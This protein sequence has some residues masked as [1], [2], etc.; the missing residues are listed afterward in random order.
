MKN[1]VTSVV[2]CA[3]LAGCGLTPNGL[4]TPTKTIEADVPVGDA[5]AGVQTRPLARP[6]ASDVVTTPEAA[7]P[8]PTSGDLGSTVASLGSPAEPGLWLKTPLVSTQ[9]TGKVSY[10]GTSIDVTLIPINGPVTAG[11]RLSLQGF[12]SLGAPLTELVEVQVSV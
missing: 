1:I 8:V 6:V 12:Q 11:S 4:K 3:A 2:I 7:K 5:A 10:N 9:S